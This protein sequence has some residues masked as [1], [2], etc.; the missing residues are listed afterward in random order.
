MRGLCGA[1][2]M[3]NLLLDAGGRSGEAATCPSVS[4]IAIKSKQPWKPPTVRGKRLPRLTSV[5]QQLRDRVDG[6]D[7]TPRSRRRNAMC[8][9]NAPGRASQRWRR[10]RR[11]RSALFFGR[12]PSGRSDL[13]RLCGRPLSLIIGNS[14][15]VDPDEDD[16]LDGIVVKGRTKSQTPQELPKGWQDGLQVVQNGHRR[17]HCGAPFRVDEKTR[18][19]RCG[20]THQ[21]DDLRR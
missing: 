19:D 18:Y 3:A 10:R 8:F 16:P 21:L 11:C 13:P 17:V 1:N 7:R 6:D 5:V 20:R 2:W 15:W 12:G 4:L 9:G 14:W